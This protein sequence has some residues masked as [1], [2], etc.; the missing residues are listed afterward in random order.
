[1]ALEVEGQPTVQLAA[2]EAAYEIPDIP[3]IGRNLSATEGARLLIFA[4]GD[5]GAP[6]EMP[7]PE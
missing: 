6:I 2:G 5:A 3:M 7:A 1:M 4:L